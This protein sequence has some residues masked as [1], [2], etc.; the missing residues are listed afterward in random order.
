MCFR[1]PAF[2]MYAYIG[3]INLKTPGW[4]KSNV[5]AWVS[6]DIQYRYWRRVILFRK[7]EH[8]DY[9]G[10]NYDFSLLKMKHGFDLP[11]IP[12]ASPAC[13]PTASVPDNADVRNNSIKFFK[14]ADFDTHRHGRFW[15]QVGVHCHLEGPSLFY[16]KRLKNQS[17]HPIRHLQWTL[18]SQ[19]T[20]T[21]HPISDCQ[22][23]YGSA[24]STPSICASATGK[25]TCQV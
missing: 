13:L 8:P 18:L 22:S 2:L 19:V 21:N 10:S 12:F 17:T 1:I 24:W 11:S 14:C 3:F 16:C 6:R 20:V 9:Y 15:L 4:H 23:A 25:D 5:E 7:I